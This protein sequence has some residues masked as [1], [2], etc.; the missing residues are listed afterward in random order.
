M[1]NLLKFE[2]GFGKIA[3]TIV[4]K[5]DRGI[6]CFTFD[7]S[8]AKD[9]TTRKWKILLNRTPLIQEN[10]KLKKMTTVDSDRASVALERVRK[11]VISLGYL[12]E[13]TTS[14][15]IG[16]ERISDID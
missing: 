6:L 15:E 4:Y 2:V 14:G 5:D 16:S 9:I 10:G 13:I 8:P 3:R 12:I 7:I 1:K 11:H